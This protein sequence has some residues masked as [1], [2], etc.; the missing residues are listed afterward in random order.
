M[1]RRQKIWLGIGIGFVVLSLAGFLARDWLGPRV[2]RAY[3]TIFYKNSVNVAFR[4]SFDPIDA[5]LSK[6]GIVFKGTPDAEARCEVK[7]Y[8]TLLMANSCD[9]I[10][11]SNSIPL[12]DSYVAEWRQESPKLEQYLLGK[13][14]HKT[15]D[16]KQSITE[17]FSNRASSKVLS[18]NYERR[19]GD[20]ICV[21]S[22]VY[23]ATYD[24]NAFFA[25][26]EC[27]RSVNFF[28]S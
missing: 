11:Q 9:I 19:Q 13:G 16:Q 27:H 12:S 28:E 10:Q 18:V 1:T 21:L 8:D 20:T 17:L 7:G 2:A 15:W 6:H 24:P 3:I 4:E 14:W 5:Q 23:T 26:R 22:M 25:N